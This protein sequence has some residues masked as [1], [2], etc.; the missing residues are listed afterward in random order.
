MEQR[1]AVGYLRTEHPDGGRPA[2]RQRATITALA[3]QHNL[4]LVDVYA[5]YGYH[6]HTLIRPALARATVLLA[7]ATATVLVAATQAAVTENATDQA[8]LWAL[9]GRP[10][11]L[12]TPTGETRF[13][14]HGATYPTRTPR[15]APLM[16]TSAWKAGTDLNL[17]RWVV[18]ATEAGKTVE[19]IAAELTAARLPLHPES[20]RT[21]W[22]P[23]GIRA[24]LRHPDAAAMRP[25]QGTFDLGSVT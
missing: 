24:V 12:I 19:Q 21:D 17:I 13:S 6:G 16:P 3:E 23:D 1:S 9:V 2:A 8:T 22:R 5:D 15:D 18:D 4:H 11:Q 20:N 10:W 7:E 25:V 14:G